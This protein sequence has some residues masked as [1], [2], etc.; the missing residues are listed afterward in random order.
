M[1]VPRNAMFNMLFWLPN[2]DNSY[3][4]DS[5]YEQ[6]FVL[7]LFERNCLFYPYMSGQF[8]IQTIFYSYGCD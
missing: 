2:S 7:F 6:V 5:Y 4:L 3:L 8:Y 1:S